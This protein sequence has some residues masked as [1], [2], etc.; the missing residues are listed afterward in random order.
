MYSVYGDGVCIYSDVFLDEKYKAI[1]PKLKLADNTAGSLEITLPI[2]NAGYSLLQRLKSVAVVYRDNVEIWSGRLITERKDFMN[3][4]ILTFEGEL[5]Y[6][7]DTSQP[8]AEFHSQSVISWLTTLLNNHNAKVTADKRFTLGAVTVY[9]NLYRF[10]NNESTLECI[11]EKLV[12]RLGGHLRVRKSG[13]V[14]YLDYLKDYPTINP[15]EIRFGKNLID[16]TRDWDMSEL[17]TVV[18]P[19][20]VRLDYSPI[21]GLDAYLDVSSVNGGSRYVTNEPGVAEY[22]WIEAVIDWDDVTIP[23]NLKAKAAEYLTIQQFNEMVIEISAVDMRYLGINV[24]SINLLDQVRCISTPHGMD[25]IFP[26]TTLSIQLDKV[27]SAVYTLGETIKQNTTG[28]SSVRTGQGSL[29]Q[30]MNDQ[31]TSAVVLAQA[32][33]N[34][35]H[36]INNATNGYITILQ[37][38]P[39]A[40]SDALVISAQPWPSNPQKYWIWNLGGLGY[41]EDGGNTFLV[42]M[43]M[44]GSI[45][46]DRVTTGVL[47]TV[48]IQSLDGNSHWNL[49]TGLFT[50]RR[51]S[52]SLGNGEFYVNDDGYLTANIGVIGGFTI[53]STS[54]YSDYMEMRNDGLYFKRDGILIGN[55]GTNSWSGSPS[56]RGLVMD[57]EQAANYASW[58]WRPSGGGNYIVKLLY[59][60]PSGAG[61]FTGDRVHLGCDM[62]CNNWR[63]Y[64]AWIDPNSGGAN[65]GMNTGRVA[66]ARDFDDE[67]GGATSWYYAE[68]SNGFLLPW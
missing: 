19:K 61:P 67:T 49:T 55:F 20:G 33:Q 8:P 51:G 9:E 45:V 68:I 30:Q 31:P 38:R 60:S 56:T 36:L 2:V 24:Q 44:D 62:D 1:S 47:S 42:A 17:V 37:D 28:S 34:A 52:I 41:T 39:N 22:G 13:G 23:A 50:M 15:Q 46:A 43:T 5:A 57:L 65:G 16:F 27:D 29:T 6:L 32:R 10:T 4:R 12:K 58:S 3:N 54:L 7:N 63:V 53:T 35:A 21:E 25:R 18:M 48:I 14:R 11:N 66:I 59:V 40:M 64:K 26:V